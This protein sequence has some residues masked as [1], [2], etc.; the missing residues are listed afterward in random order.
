M[1][2]GKEVNEATRLFLQSWQAN[3]EL[4]RA[5]QKQH[6]NATEF[7]DDFEQKDERLPNL[8]IQQQSF[9]ANPLAAEGSFIVSHPGPFT[10]PNKKF[11]NALN[12]GTERKDTS[13]N[14][15]NAM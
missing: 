5:R 7:D 8:G 6:Q 1:L 13:G 2:D 11:M 14:V 4:K 10:K 15:I 12:K 3:K 9:E